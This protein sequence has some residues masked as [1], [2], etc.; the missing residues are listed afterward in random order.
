MSF[1]TASPSFLSQLW[2]NKFASNKRPRPNTLN[3]RVN[4]L[5]KTL[6]QSNPTHL[7]S[8][9]LSGTFPSISTT[10]TISTITVGISQGDDTYQRFGAHVDIQRLIIKGCLIP[11]TTAATPATVRVT[12]LR[13]AYNLAFAA[14]MTATYSPIADSVYTRLL[15]DRFF[16]VASSQANQ[17]FATPLNIN[18]KIKHRQ[19][20]GTNAAG[21][22]SGEAIFLIIQS[23]FVAGTTAPVFGSGV[24]ECYFKP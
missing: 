19:K 14:N 9:S 6:K 18:L 11:G 13:G 15:Y 3:R 24:W 5:Y 7:Y 21:S 17:G 4:K 23:N 8:N 22:E 16:T 12:V 20:F 2:N 1:E 10:G